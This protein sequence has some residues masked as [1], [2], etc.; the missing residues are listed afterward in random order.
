M[1]IKIAEDITMAY[2]KDGDWYVGR[3]MEQPN[4]ISQGH[5]L[6][7]LQEN[8]K[9]AYELVRQHATVDTVKPRRAT[10]AHA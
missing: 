5:T 7:E 4:A 9:E 6:Q 2:E 10:K 3:I 1:R 8:I